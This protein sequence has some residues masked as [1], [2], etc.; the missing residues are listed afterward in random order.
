MRFVQIYNGGG[1]QQ[2]TWDAHQGVEENLSIHCPETDQPIAMLLTDL[3]RTG[4]LDETLVI[5]GGEFGRQ[6]VSQEAVAGQEKSNTG[7]DHNPKGFTMWMAGAGIKPGSVGETDELGSQAVV[8]RHHIRD[9]HTTVLHLMGLDT[10]K[11]TYRYGGLER[12]LTGVIE[13][14]LIKGVLA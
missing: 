1:H 8:E 6:P 14:E 10:H 3:E 2:Q 12:K 9:L 7:R 4:L 13:P 5:W 11:L